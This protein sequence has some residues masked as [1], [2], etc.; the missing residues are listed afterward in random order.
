M[1][2]KTLG[3][4][5][6][7][8]GTLGALGAGMIAMPLVTSTIGI[9]NAFILILAVWFLA[10][11]S[12]LLVAELCRVNDGVYSLHGVAG[13]VLG[14]PGQLIA[15]VCTMCLPYALCAAY[16]AGG[17][18]HLSGG[19]MH[20][21]AIDLTSGESAAIICVIFASIIFI[22]TRTVDIVTRI[23]FTVKVVAL[24]LL[25]GM[26]LRHVHSEYIFFTPDQPA[27]LWTALP[28]FFTAF[29]FQGTVPS[30]V[31]YVNKDPKKYRPAILIGSMVPFCVYSLWLLSTNGVL[32]QE[33]LSQM[34]TKNSVSQLIIAISD[35]TGSIWVTTAINVFT[36]LALATSFLGVA[37]GLFDYLSEVFK[38]KE[39]AM[40]RL[41][42]VVITFIP[43]LTI[44]LFF[45]DSFIAALGFASMVLVL[46]AV[47]LPVAMLWK[48]RHTFY[49]ENNSPLFKGPLTIV[50]LLIGSS[51]VL[52]QIAVI[53]S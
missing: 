38:Q 48:L 17:A 5:L 39:S 46:M 1:K 18:G 10:A 27:P 11:W 24:I 34:H 15:A 35:T 3:S 43:P 31:R 13:K 28:L 51:I 47:F 8:A 21:F 20:W 29:G 52:S 22:S 42:T 37:L 53:V 9:T 16:I 41:F 49:T 26:L 6:I 25:L 23:L 4:T 30:I 12:G 14:K 45:P 32:P 2:N 40:G 36:I 50:A 19:L 44:A 33:M 7:I